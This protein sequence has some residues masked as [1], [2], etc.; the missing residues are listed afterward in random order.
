MRKLIYYV[1]SSLDG[2]IAGPGDNTEVFSLP[3]SYLRHLIEHFPET[4]PTHFHA[5]MGSEATG[6]RFDTV[7]M[8]RKTYDPA[9]QVGI[10][11]PYRHLR[12]YVVSRNLPDS[13]DPEVT[14]V[15]EN[16]V[17]LIQ[18]LKQE[19]S[20]RHIWLAGGGSL[21]GQLA[22]E[23]DEIILKLNP[24]VIGQGTPVFAG[25]FPLQRFERISCDPHPTGP[26]LL[27]YRAVRD[28]RHNLS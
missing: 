17:G 5:A 7:V 3:E 12:Q 22:E 11:S 25:D 26:V 28:G 13:S 9:L 24:M 2:F 6:K 20:D 21:A 18:Q 27:H 1:A 23:I 10:T 19:T 4:L 14:L 8:G 15:R 16:V